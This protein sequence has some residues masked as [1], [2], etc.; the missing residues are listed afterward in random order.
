MSEANERQKTLDGNVQVGGKE[1][2]AVLD[3]QDPEELEFLGWT[4]FFTIGN[5]FVVDRDW[6]EARAGELGIPQKLLPRPTSKKRAFGRAM[7]RLCADEHSWD[8]HKDVEIS[9]HKEDHKEYHLEVTDRRD[10]DVDTAKI[11]AFF[12]DTDLDPSGMR[13]QVGHPEIDRESNVS[14]VKGSEFYELFRDYRKALSD[15][16]MLMEQSNLGEDIRTMIRGYFT[17]KSNSVKLRDGGAVYFAPITTE[18]VV[19]AMKQLVDDINLK[20]K[21]DGFPA[22]VDNIEVINTEEKRD[23]VE[24]RVQARVKDQVGDALEQAFE[25][26]DE[27]EVIDEVVD[28]VEDRLA[29]V[30]DFAAE[31][32]TLLDVEIGV[33]EVLEDWKSN[34][35][36]EKE[37]LIE[38]VDN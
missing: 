1:I 12:W 25:E 18:E 17:R 20:W 15:E 8:A 16:M 7:N 9:V 34:V 24:S 29:E 23:M 27:T 3:D 38:K 5:D 26:M 28:T 14:V 2:G 13:A 11:G 4:V 6:L 31:Y 22:R 32:N 37:E 30:E 35:T 36:D 19:Q 21:D 33:E 10:G